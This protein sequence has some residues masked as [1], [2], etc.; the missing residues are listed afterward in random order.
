MAPTRS[1][2]E[3]PLSAEQHTPKSAD[4][5][6]APRKRK[7]QK[8][9]SDTTFQESGKKRRRQ[10]TTP[11]DSI[12]LPGSIVGSNNA[13]DV[14]QIDDDEEEDEEDEEDVKEDH[15]EEEEAE[16]EEAEE[17]DETSLGVPDSETKESSGASERQVSIRMVQKTEEPTK[18]VDTADPLEDTVPPHNKTDSATHEP[19]RA[20]LTK[21]IHK[22]FGSEETEI[23]PP[24]LDRAEISDASVQVTTSENTG[25]SHSG[26]DNSED[27]APEM[28]TAVAGLDQAR[29]IATRA[30]GVVKRYAGRLVFSTYI[31]QVYG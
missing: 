18:T 14:I 16:E 1:Q 4:A 31:R 5:T 13:D 29:K 7:A 28:V 25:Q 9:S 22:R 26:E 3:Y 23:V 20:K 19:S 17:E 2:D 8:D 11:E 12:L 15:E 21:G 6:R 30:A 24:K 10:G 27:E